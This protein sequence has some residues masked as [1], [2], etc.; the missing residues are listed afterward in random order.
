MRMFR[1]SRYCAE[2]RLFVSLTDYKAYTI[3]TNYNTDLAVVLPNVSFTNTDD[4]PI[5]LMMFTSYKN[6]A[7]FKRQFVFPM[8][9]CHDVSVKV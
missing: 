5:S 8:T 6:N 9:T 7:L 4:I 2:C 3:S 1:S